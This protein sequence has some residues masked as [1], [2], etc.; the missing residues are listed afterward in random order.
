MK[1]ESKGNKDKMLTVNEYLDIIIL[2]LSD[3]INE[4]KT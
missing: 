2:Y 4:N 3:L 1:Y